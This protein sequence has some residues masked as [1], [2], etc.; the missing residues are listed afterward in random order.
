MARK[1]LRF[2]LSLR[3]TRADNVRCKVFIINE[4]LSNSETTVDKP[5]SFKYG[6]HISSES[7]GLGVAKTSMWQPPQAAYST[8]KTEV[9]ISHT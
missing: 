5:H 4:S 6:T 1:K 9:I 8:N 7:L 2:T 3:R